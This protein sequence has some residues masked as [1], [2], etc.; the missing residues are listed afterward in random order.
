MPQEVQMLRL[1]QDATCM[2]VR[3]ASPCRL[4]FDWMRWLNVAH[5]GSTEYTSGPAITPG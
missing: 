2:A 1:L 3:L 5:F 4:Y